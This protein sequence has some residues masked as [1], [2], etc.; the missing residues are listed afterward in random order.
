[1]KDGG[2]Q[3]SFGGVR[4]SGVMLGAEASQVGHGNRVRRER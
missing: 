1:M 4:G 2:V 3:W